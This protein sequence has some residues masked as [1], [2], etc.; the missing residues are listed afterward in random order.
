MRTR[1]TAA[2]FVGLATAAATAAAQTY[3]PMGDRMH[4]EVPAYPWQGPTELEQQGVPGATP[5]VPTQR[6]TE[7]GTAGENDLVRSRH[8]AVVTQPRE[9]L[10]PMGTRE[11]FAD[12]ATAAFAASPDLPPNVEVATVRALPR[13]GV[14]R[15]VRLQPGARIPTHWTSSS[16]ELTFLRGETSLVGAASLR[17]MEPGSF[18]ALEGREV[19]ELDCSARDTCLILVRSAGPLDIHYVGG[20]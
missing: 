12:P 14:E 8:G 15:Y 11:L 20:R 16:T 7:L 1:I 17:T 2:A 6:S 3:P 13:G 4:S 9:A 10:T 18:V 5:G 19:R